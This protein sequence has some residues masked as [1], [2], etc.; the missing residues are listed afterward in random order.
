MS[1]SQIVIRLM[2]SRISSPVKNCLTL[3][4]EKFTRIGAI[5]ARIFKGGRRG[6]STG[7][8][9]AIRGE[10]SRFVDDLSHNT[11]KTGKSRNQAINA[12]ITEDFPNL[13]LTYIPQYS[14]Y[15]SYGMAKRGI[16]THI[17]TKSFASRSQL[18]DTVI[19]EEL[20]HRWWKRGII[21]HHPRGSA[22]ER[23]FY[24]IVSRYKR[25]RGWQKQ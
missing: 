21:N 20:H 9:T 3:I 18:R 12:I 22:R 1:C 11:G 2:A 19:H 24:R 16:G 6:N 15:V 8:P 10:P 4:H 13:K 23:R 5:I 17:G 25:M 7:I 14:P